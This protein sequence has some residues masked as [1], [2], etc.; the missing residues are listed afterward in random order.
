MKSTPCVGNIGIV[1]AS[2]TGSRELSVRIHEF[3]GGVSQLIG[4]GGR[5]LSEKIGGLMMLDAIGMLENDPQTGN[6]RT[7]FKTSA[8]AV[9]RKVLERAIACRKAGGGL[10]PS[11]ALETPVDE[12]GLQL[13][14]GSKEAALKA[15]MLSGVKQENLD[16][17]TLNQPLIAGCVRVCNRS[18]NTY[19][20]CSAAARYRGRNH[21]RGDGK[22]GDVYSN[23]QPDP[24][25]RLQD[26]NR[27]IKHTFLDF[28]DD[29]FTNG[30]PHPMIDPPTASVA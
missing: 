26:I 1:G 10:F 19:V 30:K 3:G 2:G 8:P 25:F 16:L 7:D 15:V 13:A 5:D 27:S 29:D 18:R 28:G 24:E 4:T 23:I 20:A 21:V 17:H 6:Y 9:A 12:Q 22:H 14:R 11:V